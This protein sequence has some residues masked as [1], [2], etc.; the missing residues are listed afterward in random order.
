MTGPGNDERDPADRDLTGDQLK[1]RPGKK[2]GK[3]AS[4][5]P[6][7]S[8][9]KT[10]GKKAAKAAKAAK[11]TTRKKSTTR[12]P[13]RPSDLDPNS[14]AA[15]EAREER[16]RAQ[17]RAE[18]QAAAQAKADAEAAAAKSRSRIA[19]DPIG[20][21]EETSLDYVSQQ[22]HRDTA[23]ERPHNLVC[24]AETEESRRLQAT[25]ERTERWQRWG[26]YLSERQW[27][28]V[29]EDY[30]ADGEAW[31]Y[32]PFD[33]SHR[34]VY[35]WGEDGLLGFTDRECRLCFALGLWNGQDDRLKERLFGLANGEGNHGEDVKEEYFY[36]DATP[37]QSYARA[38][39]KYP[40][41]AYPYHMLRDINALRD[42]T[43]REY[44][45]LDTGIFQ[46]RRYFDVEVE[47]AKAAPDDICIRITAHNR[48]PD[49]AELHLVPRLWFRNTWVWGCS[50]EG[51][52]MKPWL[53]RDEAR[54]QQV[55][56]HWHIRTEHDTLEPYVFAIDRSTLGDDAELLYCEHESNDE[57]LYGTPS[58]TK[59]P[60]DAFHRRIVDGDAEAT[61]PKPEGTKVA[62]WDRHTIGPGESVQMRLRL[63][64]QTI[65]DAGS[66]DSAF[67]FFEEIFARRR[68]E[69]DEFYGIIIPSALDTERNRVSR[70]A[71]AGLV[72]TKQFYNYV[73]E[74]WLEGD[75]HEP[76]PPAHRGDI[77]NGQWKHLFNRDIISVCDKW[78]YPWYAAW[79]LAFHMLPMATIDPYFAKHQLILFTREW[80]MHPNGQIPAYEWNFGDVN[81][82]VHAWAVWRVYKMTGPEGGRDQT[83]LA[84]GF[85]K[86]LLNFTW[87]TNRKDNNGNNLFSGGFLGMDNIGV[88]DRSKPGFNVELEQADG[89]A[90]M[91]FFSATMLAM[92]IELARTRP[93]Y[94]SLASK[95]FE[96]F[97]QIADAMNH[98]D[99]GED[100]GSLW[101]EEDGFYYDRLR[102]ENGQPQVLR[103][104]SMVGLVP[105]FAVEVIEQETL[106]SLPAFRRRLKWF[107]KNKPDMARQIALARE[108]VDDHHAS[109]RDRRLVAIP[110]EDRL[111]RV[112]RYLADPDEFLS[113]Y[114]IRSLSKY[115]EDHPFTLDLNY[116]QHSVSYV[117]GESESP[118]FG[119]NSNWRGP[120]WM[121]MNYLLIEA[122]ERYH[123]FY[124]DQFTVEYPYGSGEQRNLR[125]IARDIERRLAKLFL[126]DADGRRPCHGDDE[127]FT[128]DPHW[129]D[130]VLYYEY[131]HGDNGR[132]L[133]ANH[134]TGW[135]ALIA[136]LLEDPSQTDDD[137]RDDDRRDADQPA[138]D[139]ADEPVPV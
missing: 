86:L 130:L 64:T 96:H 120:I 100:G 12:T 102:C 132:G 129:Q 85:L 84:R 62:V 126:P 22:E 79:D 31:D 13:T 122:L 54:D 23:F 43:E 42:R 20:D 65:A 46:D 41:K 75:P 36:L 99:E 98:L 71:Y 88:F 7:G 89:T 76:P 81:P 124:G 101:D 136:K 80:Y 109:Y 27:G 137:R 105:L 28:T 24:E 111:R 131:F 114:G 45:L 103:T 61:C 34:R 116:Q 44:E 35:R 95:F 5:K 125:Q 11:K 112:L 97:V 70:Q 18:D 83:F 123:R 87:W 138:A 69:A 9:K 59:Y 118:M 135:T 133:G 93:E 4:K 108:S 52:T 68:R 128:T 60:T 48:G 113:E 106:D 49:P 127:R 107:V 51:C 30:S 39:Y 2:A 78:E 117:P 66:T 14:P 63:T 91:A 38:L 19:A 47:Y 121:P 77:R 139:P 57:V 37:T 73:V 92:A 6:T 8:R 104:R 58:H 115:H 74:Y 94:E 21:E 53:G 110:S 40:H 55:G 1:N 17:R 16:R 82:P 25:F 134:Q 90:W 3:K 72:W 50:H 119:G 15:I 33:D 32:F 67:Q 56:G 26:S 10:G 29:R